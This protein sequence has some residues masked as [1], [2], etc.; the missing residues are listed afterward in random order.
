VF[1]TVFEGILVG[2]CGSSWRHGSGGY[3]GEFDHLKKLRMLF[4]F[5]KDY[6]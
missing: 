4:M 1:A 5:F 6:S 2:N 3:Y